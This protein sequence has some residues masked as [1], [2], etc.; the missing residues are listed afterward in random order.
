MH[1]RLQPSAIVVLL[2]EP[3][4]QSSTPKKPEYRPITLVNAQVQL[5]A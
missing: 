3:D 1:E 4:S 2:H 5:F